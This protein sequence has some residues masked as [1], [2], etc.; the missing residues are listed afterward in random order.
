MASKKISTTNNS[1][2]LNN[3]P[4]MCTT[5]FVTQL[6]IIICWITLAVSFE[7]HEWYMKVTALHKNWWLRVAKGKS[8]LIHSMSKPFLSLHAQIPTL[9]QYKLLKLVDYSEFFFLFIYS[10][11][12]PPFFSKKLWD[13]SK[14][15]KQV[16]QWKS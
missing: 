3:F 5:T 4:R 7:S 9:L 13:C 11:F 2:E 16:I 8:N 10:G 1:N 15:S 14:F 6:S 12:K